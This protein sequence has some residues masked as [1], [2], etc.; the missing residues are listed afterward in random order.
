MNWNTTSYIAGRSPERIKKLIEQDDA[1]EH[2]IADISLAYSV[3]AEND[4]FGTV[5]S[6]VCCKECDAKVDEEEDNE[7]HVCVD[8]LQTKPQKE[9]IQWKWYDFYP[10][11][12]DTPMFVCNCCRPKE[13]HQRRVANDRANYEAEF[14]HDED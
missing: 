13:K 8:C 12:G 14:G 7:E 9:G 1:C 5:G 6:C 4:S 3:R 10:A 11:Q 2:V